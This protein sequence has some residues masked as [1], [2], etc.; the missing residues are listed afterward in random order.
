MVE[1]FLTWAHQFLFHHSRIGS[2][3]FSRD[4]IHRNYPNGCQQIVEITR[5]EE[6]ARRHL[7]L[8][9]ENRSPHS[10]VTY[11]HVYGL[12]LAKWMSIQIIGCVFQSTEY[13]SQWSGSLESKP[14]KKTRYSELFW[15]I[16]FGRLFAIPFSGMPRIC[17]MCTS[18]NSSWQTVTFKNQQKKSRLNSARAPTQFFEAAKVT[19]PSVWGQ[20]YL[21]RHSVAT[22]DSGCQPS[23]QIICCTWNGQCNRR[24]HHW[25]CCRPRCHWQCVVCHRSY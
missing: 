3:S 17:K 25:V 21:P 19:C 2:D 18:G 23:L 13:S 22:S 16:V 8:L 15:V 14:G 7:P 6:A 24:W 11:V 4:H 9:H 5:G 20:R 1:V 12:W 10:N